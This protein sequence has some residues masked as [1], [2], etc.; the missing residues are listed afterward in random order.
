MIY[1]CRGI[2]RN[3]DDFMQKRESSPYFDEVILGR[4]GNISSEK[5]WEK[6]LSY[7]DLIENNIPKSFPLKEAEKSQDAIDV[8]REE[9]ASLANLYKN[10]LNDLQKERADFRKIFDEERLEASKKYEEEK[11]R[12]SDEAAQRKRQFEVHKL[13]E[14]AVLQKREKELDDRQQ[15]LDDRQHMHARRDLRDRIAKNFKARVGKPLISRHTSYIRWAVFSLTLT[16]GAGIGY[17]GIE[18]FGEAVDAA[19]KG[20]APLWLTIGLLVRGILLPVLGVGFIVY[21]INWLRVVYLDDVRTERRYE[22]NGDDIDRASFVIETLME[23]G[24]KEKV[25]VP[26]AWVEGVCRNLFADKGESGGGKAPSDAVTVL[27][28]AI[29]GA[30]IGPDGTEISMDRRGARKLAKE[31]GKQ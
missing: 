25:D 22:S 24:E 12:L 27:L 17:F 6:I 30:K 2:T 31:Y 4:S 20:G 1:F 14:E 5:I 26:D 16:F 7:V 13:Q 11:N 18:G 21:A 3:V 29:S 15:E 28:E 10:A 9:I 23:V 8:L 19:S